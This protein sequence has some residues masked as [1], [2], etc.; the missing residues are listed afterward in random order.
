[1]LIVP[2][3]LPVT[4]H[5]EIYP[6]IEPSKF[7]DTLS[8]KVV[9]ITGASRGI[10]EATALAFAHSGAS[11]FLASRKT[12]TMENVKETILKD[13]PNAKVA[14]AAADVVKP[15]DVKAAVDACIKDFGKIDI[16][17]SNSGAA[18]NILA[19]TEQDP[20][21]W[22]NTWE[23]NVRGSFNVAHYTLPHLSKTHGYLLF[24]SSI[25]AQFVSAGL[26]GY[27]S[28]K[29]VLNRLVEFIIA[30]GDGN[31]KAVSLHP[32]GI[33]TEMSLA[34]GPE[35]EQWLIDDVQLPAWTMVRLVQ[36]KEDYLSGRYV[37][38]NW[39]LDEVLAKWKEPIVRDD[40][41]KNK[42][43]VPRELYSA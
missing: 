1:M 33:K 38:S 40:A 37:S 2:Q 6:G 36:G 20:N 8:G 13:L 11:L 7:K 32:G 39:D 9:F 23:V 26:S 16:V 35:V 3:D 4:L 27:Q 41:L 25:G 14:Y 15:E 10:G 17:I 43:A 22:W 29:H 5:H 24:V 19:M 34:A 42:L 28:T 21:R 31:V 12:S 30:E 18:E